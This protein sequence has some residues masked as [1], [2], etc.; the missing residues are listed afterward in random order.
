MAI[1]KFYR[2]RNPATLA[3]LSSDYTHNVNS[4]KVCSLPKLGLYDGNHRITMARHCPQEIL[5]LCFNNIHDQERASGYTMKLRK[6]S[7]VEVEP[8]AASG[9]QV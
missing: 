2:K 3:G 6:M 7:Y 5:Q 4:V 9:I 8:V 1:R